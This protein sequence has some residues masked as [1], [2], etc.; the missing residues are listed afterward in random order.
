[1]FGGCRY[2]HDG[3]AKKVYF[4]P[5]AQKSRQRKIS[6]PAGGNAGITRY[7]ACPLTIAFF[8]ITLNWFSLFLRSLV[9]E[10]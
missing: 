6:I 2:N 9:S 1:M 8:A 5:G 3:L 4:H 10:R 7:T